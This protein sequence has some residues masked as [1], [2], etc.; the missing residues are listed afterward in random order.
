M[1]AAAGYQVAPAA[2][3]CLA[4][5]EVLTDIYCVEGW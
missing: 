1:R 5:G 3:L 2:L 4:F